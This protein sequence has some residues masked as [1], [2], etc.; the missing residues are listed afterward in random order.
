MTS[1][2]SKLNGLV[3]LKPPSGAKVSK[4]NAYVILKPEV[5][6]AV[7]SIVNTVF[8]SEEVQPTHRR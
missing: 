5:R 4:A 7:P 1:D 6:I 8:F 2:V 3:V